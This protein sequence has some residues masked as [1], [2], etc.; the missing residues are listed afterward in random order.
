MKKNFKRVSL[1][2]ALVLVSAALLAG[3]SKPSNNAGGEAPAVDPGKTYELKLATVVNPPH[4]WIDM[5]EFFAEEVAKRT[6]GKV[7]VTVYPSG[8]LGSDETTVD[9]MR[10]GTIDFVIGGTQ[11][12][13]SF[14]PEFQ[15]FGLSYLFESAEEFERVLAQDSPVT[16][17]FRDL[18]A[19]KKLGLKLLGLSNGGS[20]NTSNNLKPIVTPNDLKGLKMR[21]PGSPME[22][23]LWGALG[24]IPTS[25][26]WNEVYSAMQTGVVNAFESTISGYSGSKTYEVA[27]F[28]SK[29]QHLYMV[30]HFTMSE[31][32]YNKLPEEYVKIIE[33]VANEASLVGSKIAMESEDGILQELVE[34]FDVKVNEVDKAA[35]AA[36]V[37]PHYK[38]LAD[39]VKAGD[40]LE[41]ILE[42]K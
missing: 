5:G 8:Q 15:V 24:A 13:A 14:V 6:D 40:I 37:T 9:E 2:M 20:R 31:L 22:A 16:Q 1:L 23:K 3:C 32:T 12:F 19:E 21:L 10:T 18:Y 28:H 36:V 34:K 27:P 39:S 26:P 41:M 4:Q 35:F 11:N 42:M 7:K 25:L 17:K 38:E 29:T 33:D 30:T